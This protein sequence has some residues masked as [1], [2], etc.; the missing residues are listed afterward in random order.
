MVQVRTAEGHHPGPAPQHMALRTGV[1]PGT[2]SGTTAAD[3][4]QA[5]VVPD[6]SHGPSHPLD[7]FKP[8]VCP[9]NNL[10]V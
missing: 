5:G 7:G 10:A 2:A 3:A 6:L 1:S 4:T 8:R 9:H